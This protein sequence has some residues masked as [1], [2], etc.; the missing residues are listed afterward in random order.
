MSEFIKFICV[1]GNEHIYPLDSVFME[2][3]CEV[4]DNKDITTYKINNYEVYESAYL[5]LKNMLNAEDRIHYL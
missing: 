1:E 4:E 2:S 5:N 3:F